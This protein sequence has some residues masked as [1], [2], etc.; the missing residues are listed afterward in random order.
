MDYREVWD[1]CLQIIRDNIPESSYRTWFEPIRPVR[2]E[3][4]T[5]TIQVPSGFFPEYIEAHY[6]D[7]LRSSMKRVIGKDAKLVYEVSVVKNSTVR[8]PAGRPDSGRE[9]PS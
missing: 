6:I 7:I 9:D 2:L 4:S 5:L 8:Y 1:N 3:G